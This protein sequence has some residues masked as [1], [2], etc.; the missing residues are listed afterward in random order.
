[1]PKKK[2]KVTPTQL[3]KALAKA[4][5]V[6]RRDFP[7]GRIKVLKSQARAEI[8]F[9]KSQ[10]FVG[11]SASIKSRAFRSKVFEPFRVHFGATG[12]SGEFYPLS[13]AYS[14]PDFSTTEARVTLRNEARRYRVRGEIGAAKRFGNALPKEGKLFTATGFTI[15]LYKKV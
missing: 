13:R 3:A 9:T 7:R 6:L 5:E 12:G 10:P 11:I 15:T 1:V 14:D 2:R 8:V 4:K